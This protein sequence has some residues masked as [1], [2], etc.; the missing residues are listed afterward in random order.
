MR[1]IFVDTNIL[2]YARDR[3][4]KAKQAL[5][6]NW[7]RALAKAHAGRLSTQVLIEFYAVA[8]HPQKLAMAAAEAQ[9][10][11]RALQ[12]WNPLPPDAALLESAWSLT[13]R[14]GFSWW[15]ALIVAAALRQQC[16]LLLS[17]DLPHNRVVDNRLTIIDPFA[18]DAPSPPAVS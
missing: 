14:Y 11:C 12:A 2:A 9:A 10:D 17:E 18:P 6:E 5:A 13:D 7:L 3:R 1:P 15:D 4:A 16:A 8:T